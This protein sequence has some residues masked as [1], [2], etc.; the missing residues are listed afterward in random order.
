MRHLINFTQDGDFSHLP[1]FRMF[2]KGGKVPQDR[3]V[4]AKMAD[5]NAAER[6]RQEQQTRISQEMSSLNTDINAPVTTQ[7]AAARQAMLQQQ[8]R[9]RETRD[10][11]TAARD[12][13]VSGARNLATTEL[14][15]RG[16][17]PGR[18]G[19][20]L[21]NEIDRIN[22]TIPDLDS[23]P[24]NY[25]D[26]SFVDR[27]L[28]GEQTAA[29]DRNTRSV[30]TAF[31]PGFERNAVGDTADDAFLDSILEQQYG[32]TRTTLERARSR[33]DLNDSGFNA[34]MRDLDT[35][36]GTGRTTLT[37]IGDT[38]LGR[39]RDELTGIGNRAANA[40][41]GWN[42]GSPDFSTDPYTT[43]FNTA[44]SRQQGSLEGDIR[45]AVGN[46]QLFD[47]GKLLG[48]GAQVQGATSGEPMDFVQSA[49]NK[50]K[51]KTDRGVGSTGVF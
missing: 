43:E 23:N 40:A 9:D 16:L 19:G 17:D 33:G 28:T 30:Q 5:I 44:R 32:D 49:L 50:N 25:F 42:L 10:R 45:G 36:R 27:V 12:S 51:N 29:R 38:V 46:T 31:A 41:S 21:N 39:Y 34:A 20:A 3:S 37:G 26:P 35:E 18:Y 13:A 24:G 22:S 47:V 14:T 8:Q 1:G 48:R 6:Q 7:E 11:F 4:E 15:R 2:Y